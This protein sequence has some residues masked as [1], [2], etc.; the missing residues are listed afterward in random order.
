MAFPISIQR[1]RLPRLQVRRLVPGESLRYLGGAICRDDADCGAAWDC[2]LNQ[3]DLDGDGIGDVCDEDAD[4]DG[5]LFGEDCDDTDPLQAPGMRELCDGIDNNCDG[6]VD[7]LSPP[8]PVELLEVLSTRVVW[9]AMRDADAYDLVTGLV[10]R[11]QLVA[12]DYSLATLSCLAS[13]APDPLAG[14]STV[15]PDVGDAAWFLS[16]SVAC[17]IHGTYDTGSSSQAA[18][19]DAGIAA[20]G[21]DC[22]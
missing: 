16:R 18:P 13:D 4:G 22:P 5:A 20:S 14:H 2:S 15:L 10:S 1:I 8:T 12:G 19:R 21:V 7:N 3:E 9:T 6:A 11:L 17:G